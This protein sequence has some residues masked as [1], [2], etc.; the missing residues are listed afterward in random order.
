MV[1]F[2]QN[3]FDELPQVIENMRLTSQYPGNKGLSLT[4]M[5]KS[6]RAA[7]VSKGNY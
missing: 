6:T 2:E 1:C 3:D 5:R 7:G 4:L